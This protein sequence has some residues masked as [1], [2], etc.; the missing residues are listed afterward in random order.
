MIQQS[1]TDSSRHQVLCQKLS[2]TKSSLISFLNKHKFI[3]FFKKN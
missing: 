1:Q 2:I 3:I